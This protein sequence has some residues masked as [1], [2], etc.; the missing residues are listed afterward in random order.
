VLA[1][2]WRAPHRPEAAAPPVAA[3]IPAPAAADGRVVRL[4]DAVV[5]PLQ[6]ARR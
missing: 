2:G 4:P 6:H 3:P 5:A 1:L